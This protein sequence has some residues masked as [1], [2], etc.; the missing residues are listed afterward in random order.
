MD[1]LRRMEMLVSAADAGSFAR[2]AQLLRIDPSTV[3]HAIAEFEKEL[4]TPLFYRT[5]RQLSLTEEGRDIVARAR[6]AEPNGRAR[7]VGDQAT[8]GAQWNGTPRE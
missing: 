2:A 7:D 5:T 3:S 8:S 4:R 1:R 6:R